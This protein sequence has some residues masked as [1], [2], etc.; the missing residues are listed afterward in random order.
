[1]VWRRGTSGNP[2]GR[3]VTDPLVRFM[4]MVEI[5]QDHWLWF[6]DRD[7]RVGTPR[8]RVSAQKG[9]VMARRWIYERLQLPLQGCSIRAGCKEPDCVNPYHARV[10][11]KTM[12][13]RRRR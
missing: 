12:R 1:M 10:G 3:P 7:P 11:K 5:R 8:F 13:R 4:R 9:N 2:E 6:G